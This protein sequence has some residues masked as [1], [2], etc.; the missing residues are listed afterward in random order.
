MP[1]LFKNQAFPISY[2]E[3][4]VFV[5]QGLQAFFEYR[6]LGIQVSSQDEEVPK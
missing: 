2:A 6:G 1:Q 3:I 4:S 5:G